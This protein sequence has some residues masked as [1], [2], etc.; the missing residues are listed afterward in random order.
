MK[1]IRVLIVDDEHEFVTALVERLNLRGME[2]MGVSDGNQALEVIK[3]NDFEVIVLDVK[4]PGISG[5]QIIQQIKQLCLNLQIVLLTGRSS[6]Q[7]E[8]MGKKLGC[9]E[10]L[11]K[12][13]D[14]NNLIQILKSAAMKNA[15]LRS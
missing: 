10:Y 11:V 14:I 12:P 8:H 3:S 5:L 4:M 7:D 15:E 13:V 1:P 2:A 6:P 9:Y